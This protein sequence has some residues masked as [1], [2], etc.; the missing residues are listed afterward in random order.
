MRSLRALARGWPGF[1]E[2]L[3]P[4]GGG[5]GLPPAPHRRRAHGAPG[6][7]RTAVNT[8]PPRRAAALPRDT[9]SSGEP[10]R[11]CLC[12]VPDR[13]LP[14]HRLPALRCQAVCSE[15]T[16]KPDTTPAAQDATTGLTPMKD[17]CQNTDPLKCS[18]RR[19]FPL[20]ARVEKIRMSF[21][22]IKER[23]L[24]QEKSDSRTQSLV[25]LHKSD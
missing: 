2:E 15:T 5:L 1:Q 10:P 12:G 19:W 9:D 4:P 16:S 8:E 17:T 24:L 23:Q 21:I 3:P 14:E 22:C 25:H 11:P 6:P 13:G 7:P 18:G 20:C